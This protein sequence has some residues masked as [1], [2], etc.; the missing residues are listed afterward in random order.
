MAEKFSELSPSLIKFIE[1]QH[2]YFVATA[3]ASGTV[4]LS[5]K[6][7]DSLKVLSKKELLWLN[8]TGSGNE[9][10]A[11]ILE[12]P[13]MTIM[14]CSFERKP[15]ILRLYG[16]AKAIHPR[17]KNWN[18]YLEFFPNTNGA[19]QFYLLEIN[20]VQT[21]CGFAVPFYDYKE[22]RKALVDWAETKGDAGIES[23]WLEK[24]QLSIDGFDTAI[25][26]NQHSKAD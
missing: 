10:A 11:H 20:L 24:N 2:I 18:K 8:Y 6:G 22:E 12:N 19:R 16:K 17:D 4:N 15:L 21:S 23:Y 7:M 5:P 1:G 9:T 3:R 13:R 26:G 14:F 25:I